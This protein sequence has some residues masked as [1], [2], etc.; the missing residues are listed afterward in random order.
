MQICADRY[1]LCENHLK[2]RFDLKDLNFYLHSAHDNS[3]AGTKEMQRVTMWINKCGGTVR[4]AMGESV[5]VVIVEMHKLKNM[6]DG[7]MQW[8][9]RNAE[10]YQEG[11][12]RVEMKEMGN[13]AGVVQAKNRREQMLLG[14]THQ[15]E[16][17]TTMN[18][19]NLK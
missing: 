16:T 9:A 1:Q 10:K 19:E 2:R 8:H 18:S 13:G 4:F 6:I 17:K 7:Y 11:G 5:S 14:V 3:G 12:S 15:I